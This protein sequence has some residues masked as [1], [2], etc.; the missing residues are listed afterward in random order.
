MRSR[1]LGF[2][3]AIGAHLAVV[4][5]GGLFF[6]RPPQERQ[7]AAIDEVDLVTDAP[8]D[9]EKSK[10]DP[11]PEDSAAEKPVDEQ[12][13]EVQDEPPPDMKE[14]DSLE[15]RVAASAPA[16]EALSLGALEAA[17]NPGAGGAGEFGGSFGLT[18]G[19]RIGGTG[20]AG[21]NGVAPEDLIFN[22]AD[23]DQRPRPIFQAAPVY[24]PE[25]RK[26]KT[27]GSVYVLFEV[28]VQGRVMNPKVEKSSHEAFSPPALAAV[29]QWKFEPAVRNG[30]K[31]PCRMRVPIRFSTS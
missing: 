25:L 28:D 17:L 21:G 22:V 10:E 4:F 26:R 8:A 18:S 23:L 2:G 27:E 12:A 20:T 19:G 3:V 31:V 14:L 15:D 29:R 13:M 1:V 5:L 11:K 16:L 6:L 30:R 9:K 7:K 24:P